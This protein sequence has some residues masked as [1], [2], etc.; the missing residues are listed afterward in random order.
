[1]GSVGYYMR[2]MEYC[3]ES[4]DCI[5]STRE[6]C[7]KCGEIYLENRV[8]IGETFIR[9]VQGFFQG[10]DY[11]GKFMGNVLDFVGICGHCV[12]N[13]NHENML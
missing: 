13:V 9:V 8:G 7:R 5:G 1:M 10:E 6:P 12:G 11:V 2:N 3:G 4:G